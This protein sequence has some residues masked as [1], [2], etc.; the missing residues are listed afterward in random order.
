MI[1]P[2]DYKISDE[3]YSGR[4]NIIYRAEDL[5]NKRQVVMKTLKNSYPNHEELKNFEY[6][7]NVMKSLG[8]VEGVLGVYELVK[9]ENALII[10]EEDFGGES[11]DK[12]LKQGKFALKE[13]LPV[14]LKIIEALGEI[15]KKNII[16]KDIKPHNILLN[17]KTSEVKIIDFG[18]S[19]Q[20]SREVQEIITRDQLEGT[21]LYIS[22]EQTGRMNRSIDY[23]TDYYSLGVTFYQ[24]L[25]GKVP[26]EAEDPMEIVHA[27]IARTPANP[28]DINHE[29]PGA[30][31]GIVMKLL[32]KNAEERYQ[33]SYGLKTDLE[34]CLKELLEKS[35]ISDFLPG[36]NDLPEKLSIPEKLYGR[37]KQLNYLKGILNEAAAG[38]KKVVIVTGEP[39]IGKS[40]LV[41]EMSKAVAEKNGFFIQGKFDQARISMPLSAII[42]AFNGLIGRLLSESEEKLKGWKKRIMEGVGENGDVIVHE[43]PQLKV[44]IGDQPKVIDLAPSEAENRFNYVFQNF[45]RVFAGKKQTLVFFLDG[46]EWADDASLKLLSAVLTDN[47]LSHFLFLG[48]YRDN[49]VG[50]E[51]K[52]TKFIDNINKDNVNLE[53]LK[54]TKLTS[55]EISK[56]LSDTLYCDVKTTGELADVIELKTRGNP[57]FVNGLIKTLY[58]KEMI[59]FRNGW[60]WD[61]DK[62]KNAEITGNVAEFISGQIL[63]LP[64]NT[65]KFIRTASCI[66]PDFHINIL[67]LVL[68]RTEQETYEAL[69]PAVNEGFLI[70]SGQK[71]RFAHDR[72]KETVYN[73]IDKKEREKNHYV[74]GKTLINNLKPEQVDERIFEVASQLNYAI[75]II[76]TQEEK[77]Y[78]AELNLKAGIRAKMSVAYDSA[79]NFLN[80]G[81][82]LLPEDSW[83]T[84]YKLTLDFHT[85][86]GEADYLTGEHEKAEK[87]FNEV[88]VNAKDIMDEVKVYSI[89]IPLNTSYNKMELAI[90][91]GKKALS[92]LGMKLPGKANPIYIINEL[93]KANSLVKKLTKK[94]G[95]EALM[96]LPILDEPKKI[97]IAQLFIQIL[98]PVFMFDA[99]YLPIIVLKLLN[100]SLRNGNSMYSAYAYSA[101]GYI[102]SSVL[103]NYKR[104]YQ[105]GEIAYMFKN[106]INTK[107]VQSKVTFALGFLLY[108]WVKPLRETIALFEESYKLSME[109]GDLE[110]AAYSID[111][112][113][114]TSILLSENLE[115]ICEKAKLFDIQSTKLKQPRIAEEIKLWQNLALNLTGAKDDKYSFS[116]PSCDE[117]A[118]IDYWKK[119]KNMNPYAFYLVFKQFIHYLYNDYEGSLNYALEVKKPL[120]G[121]MGNSLYRDS[122]YFYAL[123]LLGN[124]PDANKNLWKKNLKTIDSI[125]KKMT[126][127]AMLCPENCLHKQLFIEAELIARFGKNEEAMRLYERAAEEA[128]KNGFAHEKAMILEHTGLFYQSIGLEKISEFYLKEAYL[129]YQSWGAKGKLQ[130]LRIKNPAIITSIES[131]Y[132]IVKEAGLDSGTISE[133]TTS[134][135]PGSSSTRGSTLDISTVLKSSNIM[136][137]EMNLE[138]LLS[139][140]IKI[141]MENAGAQKGFLIMPDSGGKLFIQAKAEILTVNEP[142]IL[143]NIPI[144]KEDKICVSIV[145]YVSNS[146]ESVVIDDA[147]SDGRWA[148]DEYIK[149]YKPKSIL[150]TAIINQG[151][152]VA[153]LYIENNLITNAFPERRIELLSTLSSQAAISIEN[154]GLYGR[155][156]D[157]SRN[158][159]VKVAER[160]KELAA[161]NQAMLDELKIAQ[162]VQ[163]SFLPKEEALRQCADLNISGKYLAMEDL[164]GDLYDIIKIDDNR[165]GFLMADVSGHG[166]SASLMTAMAKASFNTDALTGKTTAEVCYSV[167]KDICLFVG[168]MSEHDLT[169]FFGIL[170]V[171]TGRFEFTNA[172]HQPAILYRR[173]TGKIERLQTGSGYIGLTMNSTYKCG[174]VFLEKGDRLVMF[175]DGIVETMNKDGDL[176][177]TKRLLEMTVK[178]AEKTPAEY[179]ECVLLDVNEFSGG[180]PLHDDRAIL[181]VDYKS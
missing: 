78:L 128:G 44:I 26:F 172:A 71:I 28:S 109:T 166:V 6:E 61:I 33:S 154:A 170:D 1:N 36:E 147:A 88:M 97:A 149:A 87:H 148:G 22:P 37:E 30:L 159:E 53:E 96:N 99:D 105:L 43:L 165:Y 18:I 143:K 107:V 2:K 74:I 65:L 4:K 72:L 49:E 164:G 103:G 24:M 163:A 173:K 136:A 126:L 60:K 150:C 181:C 11:I 144:E 100:F 112:N 9:L 52:L 122:Y 16:H 83:K 48:A 40:S 29:I 25:T 10:V 174:E 140:T 5:R 151:R 15:H 79:S 67:S 145:R 27:H 153:I 161:K 54:L 133:S 58:D 121:I 70:A 155:L 21:L 8:G 108:H 64:E 111:V 137:G 82:S 84:Y 179:I 120:K 86:A 98:S 34:R 177:D 152:L 124:Y 32:S 134:K 81:L 35:K 93:L 158:L 106:K 90:K 55:S 12:I 139:K 41:N 110:Y 157:Y 127:W 85:E 31:S 167:N 20:L 3:I 63:K 50:K 169:V 14:G 94:K 62:I 141:L 73:L 75:G 115:S 129:T 104:G 47:S 46:M 119:V 130:D 92:L 102:V 66:G 76:N 42:D 135:R 125:L 39:G 23:R 91:Q 7:Y 19:T 142:D 113:L 138:A 80:A 146:R 117:K 171:G 89:Q 51:S 57:F 156:E 131:D 17:R 132:D 77:I 175:T 123:S 45:I 56:L 180:A 69:K 162:K 68:G 95:I 116:G 168:E 13:F 160:T 178:C 38:E 176:Y 101:Y 114:M 118:I 59:V